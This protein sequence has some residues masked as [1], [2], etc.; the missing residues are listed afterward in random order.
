[1]V[2][3]SSAVQPAS[4]GVPGGAWSVGVPGVGVPGVGVPASVG[5]PGGAW[6]LTLIRPGRGTRM[7]QGVT[8]VG[9]NP[10]R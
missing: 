3:D 5:V 1:M 7:P 10:Q 4:V 9:L 2:L 6:S 8:L